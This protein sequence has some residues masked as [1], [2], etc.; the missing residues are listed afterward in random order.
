VL[1]ISATIP[2]HNLPQGDQNTPYADATRAR[3]ATWLKSLPTPVGILGFT[4]R[5]A[6]ELDE[7][8]ARTGLRVPEDVAILGVGNDLARVEFAHVALSSIQLNTQNIGL[9]AAEKLQTLM[10]G[11]SIA[12][13]ETLVRP[14][15]IVTRRSTDRFAVDDEVV[16]QA[17]DYIREHVG[18]TIYVE[19][20]A[21]VA[22]VNRRVLELR[23][24]AALATSVYAEV[25]RQ[26]FERALELMPEPTL[27]L[28]EIA[29]ASGFESPSVFASAFRRRHG[30]SPSEYRQNL[31]GSTRS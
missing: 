21:R 15:K 31:T 19:D 14:Q 7:A 5:V 24:R 13:D 26:H 17:L 30:K 25:Q 23:F 18:N 1:G 12:P 27:T 6:L 8:A 4:D 29:Y 9:Q 22:G 20:I 2:R 3:L 11:A 16:A 28:G 10:D